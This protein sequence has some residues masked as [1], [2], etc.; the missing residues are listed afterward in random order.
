MNEDV[1]YRRHPEFGGRYV[2]RDTIR[3]GS[4]YRRAVFEPFVEGLILLLAALGLFQLTWDE[5]P[6]DEKD[7]KISTRP[8]LLALRMTSLGRAVFGLPPGKEGEFRLKT[9][10]PAR[11]VEL[12]ERYL[13]ARVDPAQKA[14]VRFF[15]E[16]SDALGSRMFKINRDLLRKKCRTYKDLEEKFNSLERYAGGEL[17]AVWERLREELLGDFVTLRAETDWVV[18]RLPGENK[19]LLDWLRQSDSACFT[20]LPGARVLVLRNEISR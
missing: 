1:S 12:D 5:V 11:E 14:A 3:S 6:E 2:Y 13:I 20:P 7:E 8:R 19:A 17:P 10:S 18:Y 15:A 9:A 4:E 16:I